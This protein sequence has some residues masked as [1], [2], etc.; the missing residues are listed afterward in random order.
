MPCYDVASNNRQALSSHADVNPCF[1]CNIS[2]YDVASN[3]C[4]ALPSPSPVPALASSSHTTAKRVSVT[5]TSRM[6]PK[7]AAAS[8]PSREGQSETSLT[9][10]GRTITM[11]PRHAHTT[12][13]ST[14]PH[15]RSS[16][17]L[18]TYYMSFSTQKVSRPPFC[19]RV[20]ILY[21]PLPR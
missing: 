2:S 3:I 7:G 1:L 5:A 12:V 4:Q 16:R 19:G 13:W 20:A 6:T 10:N 21:Y 9:L 14:P 11:G 15:T 8:A 17:L 18:Y